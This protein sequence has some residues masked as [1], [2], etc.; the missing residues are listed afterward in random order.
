MDVVVSLPM[1]L[2]TKAF[3]NEMKMDYIERAVT[4]EAMGIVVLEIAAAEKS[5]AVEPRKGWRA[6]WPLGYS[7]GRALWFLR[8]GKACGQIGDYMLQLDRWK[9]YMDKL[10]PVVW[11]SDI[12]G[13]LDNHLW[14]TFLAARNHYQRSEAIGLNLA[15]AEILA[16]KTSSP[17]RCIALGGDLR[18]VLMV[19]NYLRGLD[20]EWLAYS[21]YACFRYQDLW[22]VIP[23]LAKGVAYLNPF[24][25][26]YRYFGKYGLDY[27]DRRYDGLFLMVEKDCPYNSRLLAAA[28]RVKRPVAFYEFTP[29]NFVIDD[30]LEGLRVLLHNIKESV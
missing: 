23:S 6:L 14:A 5:V 13:Y 12:I 15:K 18:Y 29:Q 4:S 17:K 8:M 1:L 16:Q 9:N 22:R 11:H 19:Q 30:C 25:P 21:Y 24:A 2:G 3:L 20:D 26:H 27:N 28:Q 10:S 7:L